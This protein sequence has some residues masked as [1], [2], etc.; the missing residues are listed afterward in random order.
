MYYNNDTTPYRYTLQCDYIHNKCTTFIIIYY[1][2]T[3]IINIIELFYDPWTIR[4]GVSD[5]YRFM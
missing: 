2:V 3:I 4:R 5:E 1:I